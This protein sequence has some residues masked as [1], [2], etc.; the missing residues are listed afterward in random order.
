LNAAAVDPALRPER[1]AP[2]Q[3]A[4]LAD[5]LAERGEPS[6]LSRPL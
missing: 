3:F 5:V 4:M 1:I 6:S 2:A